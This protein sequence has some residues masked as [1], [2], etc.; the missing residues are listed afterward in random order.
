MQ[1]PSALP[2]ILKG[3]VPVVQMVWADRAQKAHGH[4][5]RAK[6]WLFGKPGLV[7][8]IVMLVVAMILHRL[9]YIGS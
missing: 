2:V 6:N 1:E 4:A 9:G 8:A 7:L 5:T 3:Y